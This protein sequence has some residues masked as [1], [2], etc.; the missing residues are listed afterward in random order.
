MSLR[1]LKSSMLGLVVFLWFFTISVSEGHA[2][3]NYFSSLAD[4][5]GPLLCSVSDPDYSS[6]PTVTLSLRMLDANLSP[7]TPADGELRFVE[8]GNVSVPHTGSILRN[9]NGL[10]INFHV[11]VDKGNRSPQA[12]A[13]RVLQDLT[14]Y[15]NEQLDTIS[16]YTNEGNN[17]NLYYPG[18]SSGS[19]AQAVSNFSISEDTK[20]RQVM[21]SLEKVTSSIER[22]SELCQKTN[23]IIIILGDDALIKNRL[24][25]YGT[26][27]KASKSKLIIYHLGGQ[28][29]SFSSRDTY[30]DFAENAGGVYAQVI[31]IDDDIKPELDD[32]LLYRQTFTIAYKSN[33]GRSGEHRIS[34]AYRDN[35]L[36]IFGPSNYQIDIQPPNVTG[37]TG[38]TIINRVRKED[39]ETQTV[40]FSQD[41]TSYVVSIVWNDAYPRG[42]NSTAKLVLKED[43]KSEETLDVVLRGRGDG[44]YEFDWDFSDK[45]NDDEHKYYLSLIVTDEFGNVGTSEQLAVTLR[46]ET[47]G[48]TIEDRW[49]WFVYILTGMVFLLLILMAVGWLFFRSQMQSIAAKGGAMVGKIA[50]E[51]RKTLIGGGQRGKALATLKVLEGPPSM[52]DKELQIFTE[53]V[54]IGRN[55]QLADMTFYGPDVLTSV[56][57]LHARL[58][59]VNGT[60]RIV[61]ISQ[62]HSETFVDEQPIPFHEPHPL[63]SGQKIRMGYPA[64]QPIVLLFSSSKDGHSRPTALDRDNNDP[65]RTDVPMDDNA[66]LVGSVGRPNNSRT[67][68]KEDDSVFDEFR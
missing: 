45:K 57:G 13:K 46:V 44:T 15:Y 4:T 22:N 32:I 30:A 63:S 27:I 43:G 49:K 53:S 33:Y 39:I 20:P 34:A 60:W 65:R 36:Q 41:S 47:D 14:Q 62:S 38:A 40:S 28:H 35:N 54:K 68:S 3:P 64:Q 52:I 17:A 5:Q 24:L 16:I 37:L 42:I 12:D 8:N 11:I 1:F 66:R 10:G 56:S 58:E 55:P 67:K 7:F 48:V 2:S 31:S 26:R 51:I 50:G 6:F 18:S 19:L 25:D 29:S 21:S 59:K 61:A 23:I 9:P